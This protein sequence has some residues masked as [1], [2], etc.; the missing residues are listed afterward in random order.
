VSEQEIACRLGRH[1][2][3]DDPSIASRIH[4]VIRDALEI[5]AMQIGVKGLGTVPR[6]A[7]FRT[8]RGK[9]DASDPAARTPEAYLGG[10]ARWRTDLYSGPTP[11][12]RCSRTARAA[13][14]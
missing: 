13:S 12:A 9:M 7:E 4:A 11:A 5:D 8:L 10:T 3:R 2:A 14:C 6:L 1:A